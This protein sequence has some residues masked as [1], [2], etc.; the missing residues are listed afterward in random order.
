V[1]S[2]AAYIEADKGAAVASDRADSPIHGATA[3]LISNADELI[4]FIMPPFQN[5]DWVKNGTAIGFSTLFFARAQQ[6]VH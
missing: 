3:K 1:R 2:G 4:I 5:C 6:L